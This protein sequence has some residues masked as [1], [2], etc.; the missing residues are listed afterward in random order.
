MIFAKHSISH[1]QH[2]IVI[3]KL[4]GGNLK[5]H[6]LRGY[7]LPVSRSSTNF[8]GGIIRVPPYSF[9]SSRSSSLEPTLFTQSLQVR[10]AETLFIL[11]FQWITALEERSWNLPGISP[12]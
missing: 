7:G 9:N 5:A 1:E 10:R 4:E 11:H 8:W 3:S 2:F 12:L 6:K